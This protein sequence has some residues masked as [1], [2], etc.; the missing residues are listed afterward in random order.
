MDFGWR[1]VGTEVWYE[2]GLAR[3]RVCVG[4]EDPSCSL[5]KPGF[6][7]NADH[8]SYFGQDQISSGACGAL[9]EYRDSV[10]VYLPVLVEALS[11]FV[12]MLPSA[13]EALH[14]A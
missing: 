6:K 1:H 2:R 13:V 12:P 10:K 9:D 11:M 5:R 3:F 8:F 14:G 4:S 7:I